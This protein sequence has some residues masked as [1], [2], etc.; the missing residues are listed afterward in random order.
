VYANRRPTECRLSRETFMKTL[1][2]KI[3]VGM[4]GKWFKIGTNEY[5]TFPAFLSI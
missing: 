3:F 2:A 5:V 4:G 1:I